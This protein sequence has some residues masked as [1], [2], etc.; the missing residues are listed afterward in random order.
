[1]RTHFVIATP[2]SMRGLAIPLQPQRRFQ[3]RDCRPRIK[4][5]GRNDRRQ[6]L[7]F[8][9]FLMEL[10]PLLPRGSVDRPTIQLSPVNPIP[11]PSRSPTI[12]T[13][14]WVLARGTLGRM[15][16]SAT[17]KPSTPRTFRR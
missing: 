7:E 17:H 2:Y 6:G 10:R 1:M 3:R 13:V 15:L 12:I 14:A 9:N 8:H 16:A 5:R 4:Y 11:R